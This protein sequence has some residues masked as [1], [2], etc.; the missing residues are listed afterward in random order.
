MPLVFGYT[1]VEPLVAFPVENPVPTHFH[2]SVE[3]QVIATAPFVYCDSGVAEMVAVAPNTYS[4]NTI[5]PT[6]KTE[7]FTVRL[8]RRSTILRN[9]RIWNLSLFKNMK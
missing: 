2:A 4:G 8:L 6:N 5:K 3:L 7:R 9:Y 1:V